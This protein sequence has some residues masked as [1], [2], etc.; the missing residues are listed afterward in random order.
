FDVNVGGTQAGSP[1]GGYFKFMSPTLTLRGGEYLTDRLTQEAEKFIEK[2]RDRPFFLYLAHY[3]VHIPLQ[4]K[5][6]V[7]AKYQARARPGVTRAGRG[8]RDSGSCDVPVSSIDFFPTILEMAG[9]RPDAE[10]P[11]DGVSLVPLLKGGKELK[12]EALYWH[13]PHYSNQGGRPGG[14]VR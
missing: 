14:A 7:V 8:T 1:T 10:H 12:R 9:V 5:K 6:D 3:A 2:N 4:A 11:V 13:Y